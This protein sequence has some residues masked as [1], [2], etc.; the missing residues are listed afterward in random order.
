M[1]FISNKKNVRSNLKSIRPIC[2]LALFVPA[3]ISG[4]TMVGPDYTKVRPESPQ[5]WEARMEKGLQAT[6]P[7]QENLSRWW[8]VFNDPVL[9]R[10]EEKAVKGNLDLKSALSRLRQARI[11]RG[12][13]RSD[14]YP[15]L[16]AG[17]RVQR[18]QTSESMPSAY[19]GK[20][21]DYYLGQFD[22]SWELDLFGGIRRSVQTA[23]AELEASQANLNDVLTSLMAEVA[24]NYI[25]VRTFQHRLAI[26]RENIETQEKTY[27]LNSS[28]Y[29]AGLVDE[30]AVQQSLRNLER[31][32]SQVS[33]LENGLIAA[34][35]R[36]SVLLG[37][38][39]GALETELTPVK[40][41]PQIPPRVAVGIPAEAMRRRPDI[42]NAERRLAAQTSR[43]GAATAELYPRFHLFGT[44]GLEAL[45][46]S[47]DFFDAKSQFWNIGPGISWNIFHGRAL[48]LN[49]DLQTEK[50]KEA[51]IAYK[52]AVLHAREEIEDALTAYAKEQMREQS[53][54]K[55]VDAAQRTEFLARDRYKAGL[56]DFY[57][58]L[59]AQRSLLELEDELT[60]S[61]GQVASS[62]A[63]LYKALG[64][65]WQFYGRPLEHA[66]HIGN[67]ENLA[68]TP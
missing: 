29:E 50:Q 31:T 44:I 17:G 58:V 3:L 64:G 25:E 40:T 13:T 8:T 18:Q 7:K 45:D 51:L 53:L 5:N 23:Q 20:E 37:L 68:Y 65:G 47:S 34:K 62:L 9:T 41:I 26:T 60:R 11:R 66:D 55:A 38:S 10:L 67:V 15:G 28:R 39:P 54:E 35:N 33:S 1:S 4:C 12:I 57:N 59:D 32:R 30:L 43:I 46:A 49:I 22:S 14:L 24:L 52:S 36:L 6:R 63:R 48:R 19:G 42:R 27:E 2:C 61:R 56:I 21:Q 16:D